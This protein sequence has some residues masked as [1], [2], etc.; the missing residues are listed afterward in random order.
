M[1]VSGC[2]TIM[3]SDVART[4]VLGLYVMLAG[5][6]VSVVAYFWWRRQDPGMTPALGLG[7]SPP[8]CCV[9][10]GAGRARGVSVPTALGVSSAPAA[11]GRPRENNT[12]H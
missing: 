1:G 10:V 5:L 11:C 9:A 12:R 4:R 7:T 8:V 3:G 6:A 2:V